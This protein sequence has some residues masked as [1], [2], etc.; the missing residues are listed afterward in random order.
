MR[1]QSLIHLVLRHPENPLPERQAPF[2]GWL[3]LAVAVASLLILVLGWHIYE[4]HRFFGHIGTE[5]VRRTE[6]ITEFR[7]L[8]WE[9]TQAT[10][11][12]VL[13]GSGEDWRK[14]YDDASRR[15][16]AAL[17]ADLD[18]QDQPQDRASFSLLAELA[19]KLGAIERNAMDAGRENRQDEA[20]SLLHSPGYTESTRL[21]CAQADAH[22]KA[23]YARLQER[24]QSHGESELV[25]FSV[26]VAVLLF[27]GGLW[28]LLG[29][30]LRRW[31]AVAESELSKRIV[32]EEQLRQA[33]KMEA[34]GQMAA[35][36]GH[37]FKNV[38]GSIQG[39]VDLA[40]RAAERGD[41]DHA[42]LRGIQAAA[43][44]GAAVTS[45]LLTF[46]HNTGPER[47][48]V[49]LCRLLAE[50]TG[51]LRQTLPAAI[52][53]VT[54]SDCPAKQ[55]QILG[56]RN[57]LQQVLVNLAN[58]AGDAMPTGGRLSI[59]LS[60]SEDAGADPT[61][62]SVRPVLCLTVSDTGQGIPPE[63]QARIFEPFFTTK[64]RGQS[65]GL[66][67]AIVHAIAVDHGATIDVSSVVGQGT[68]FRLCFPRDEAEAAE[69][70]PPAP[71][72]QGTLL[73]AAGDLYY[74]QLLASAVG[75]LG[76]SAERVADWHGL[77]DALERHRETALTVLVDT[78]FTDCRARDYSDAFAATG[79]H[80]RVLILTERDS[81]SVREYEDA[82]FM[83]L[84]RP[85][86]L[87]ELVRLIAKGGAVR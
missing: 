44:Q 39:Y 2:R 51:L 1:G 58:N 21:L 15:L 35:G 40:A 33:Q 27:A 66:G 17:D 28:W 38:L 23:V 79:A 56:D 34:L 20:L 46:S 69:G 31:R 53:I 13:F 82:G 45:A 18:L 47:K 77:L 59:A 30:R 9:M 24:L 50:T 25:F 72:L 8:R 16:T 63:I 22:A 65:T 43:Q 84:E 3:V 29:V 81:P 4:S 12:V 71:S 19:R 57:Q 52:E 85:L 49:N 54:R 26:D 80:P 73:I 60:S 14:A 86:P 78:E 64:G 75:R 87:A 32:A 41:I 67:L 37:D 62:T 11:H 42:S 6:A 5:F 48:L 76:L 68:T 70:S 83:V 7:A 10:H 61:G 36:V 74:A 55:C